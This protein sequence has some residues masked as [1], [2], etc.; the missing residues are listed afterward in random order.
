MPMRR[1]RRRL[2]LWLGLL[3]VVTL[4]AVLHV[5]VARMF[6]GGSGGCPFGMDGPAV[7]RAEQQ[8]RRHAAMQ[9]LKGDAAAGRRPAG[10]FVLGATTRRDVLAWAEAE[11]A[12]CQP[13]R[14]KVGLT[15]V[16][17]ASGASPTGKPR[18][19]TYLDFGPDDVLLGMLSM[20]YLDR[21]AD[22]ET[23]LAAAR[24]A[25]QSA[26]GAPTRTTNDAT[27]SYLAARPLRQ[28]RA[29]YRRSNYYA[30]LSAT[31]LGPGGYLVSQVYQAID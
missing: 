18:E 31:N 2:R 12:R 26:V 24:S 5:P 13:G 29:E 25:L 23:A 9:R 21:A 28:A 11:G 27:A 16:A 3:A 6:M 4:V 30:S 10:Q 15:C 8:E 20:T 22:A 7:S 17:G 1:T 19:Q 14:D